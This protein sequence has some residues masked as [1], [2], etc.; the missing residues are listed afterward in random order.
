MPQR[1]DDKNTGQ[2]TFFEVMLSVLASAFGVQ[3]SKN[4]ERDFAKGNPVHFI[5]VGIL[6]TVIFVVG[7][8]LLVNTIITQL[9]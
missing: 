4:R 8:V 3:S 6:F 7:M 2:L 1:E 5:M 9:T